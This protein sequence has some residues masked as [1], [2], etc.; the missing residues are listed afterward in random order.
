MVLSRIPATSELDHLPFSDSLTVPLC[1]PVNL[2]PD[3]SYNV[4]VPVAEQMQKL[5]Q[6]KIEECKL[7]YSKYQTACSV[8]RKFRRSWR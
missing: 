3:G 5:K 8:C 4:P 7:L 6:S 1:V 2:A